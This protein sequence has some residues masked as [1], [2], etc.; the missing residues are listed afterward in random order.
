MRLL[1]ASIA[2]VASLAGSATGTTTQGRIAFSDRAYYDNADSWEI[3]VVRPD[4]TRVRR[5]THVGKGIFD[6]IKSRL[7]AGRTQDRLSE[8]LQ[9]LRD[10]RERE[11][12]PATD[13]REGRRQHTGMVAEGRSHRLRT[14]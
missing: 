9:H 12:T 13:E 2:L 11:A 7:V 8:L 10:G 5:V 14:T 6:S 3:Y 4:G 1:V